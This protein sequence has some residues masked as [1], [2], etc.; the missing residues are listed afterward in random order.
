MGGGTGVLQHPGYLQG[1]G[2]VPRLIDGK[3]P[4]QTGTAGDRWGDH[5]M[6]SHAK[7]VVMLSG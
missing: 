4:E 2:C 3:L 1:W 6:G 7:R 5:S